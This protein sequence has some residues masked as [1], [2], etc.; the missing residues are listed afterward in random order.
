MLSVETLR[1]GLEAGFGQVPSPHAD[2]WH[3]TGEEVNLIDHMTGTKVGVLDV[4]EDGDV[5]YQTER[6]ALEVHGTHT[7]TPLPEGGVI[8]SL[9]G[10]KPHNVTLFK[11]P[12]FGLPTLTQ[13]EAEPEVRPEQKPRWRPR[14]GPPWR[15]TPLRRRS[16]RSC[17]TTRSRER[18]SR[19][20]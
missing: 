12:R 16:G 9:P 11:V 10:I 1:N 5:V 14:P 13:A 2:L 18:T 20:S 17:G 8:F 15:R 4:Y 3:G 7:I 19:R 6:I